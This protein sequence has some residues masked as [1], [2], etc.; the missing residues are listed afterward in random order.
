MV[1]SNYLMMVVPPEAEVLHG[2]RAQGVQTLSRIVNQ[3]SA[4]VVPTSERTAAAAANSNISC[5]NINNESSSRGEDSRTALA[6]SL[7]G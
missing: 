5:S 7:A 4:T 2:G 6:V 1:A 3:Q